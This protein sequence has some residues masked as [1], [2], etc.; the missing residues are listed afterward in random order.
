MASAREERLAHNETL[1]R[2]ANERMKTWEERHE[3]ERSE[4]YYCE[5][6]RLDCRERVELDSAQY[7]AV[8]A[9]SH[10]FVV[11]TD[12]ADLDI[13][14]IIERADGYDIVE[15][16]EAVDHIVVPTDPRG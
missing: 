5:C 3:G 14:R 8:R 4:I 12:H 15:K 1:Y 11:A 9:D 13:E 2:A 7:E 6:S 10:H 16:P